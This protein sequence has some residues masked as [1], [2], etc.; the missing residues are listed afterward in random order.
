MKFTITIIS[1]FLLIIISTNSFPDMKKNNDTSQDDLIIIGK[2]IRINSNSVLCGGLHV[3]T[4]SEYSDLKVIKGSYKNKSIF[5]VHG[6]IELKR[7]QYSKDAGTLNDFVIGDYHRMAV[8]KYNIYKIELIEKDNV[9]PKN[10]VWFF[11]K[12]VDKFEN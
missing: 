7:Q 3:G 9:D 4:M 10:N 1:A 8:S 2:L 11:C 5:V 12:T 6:C